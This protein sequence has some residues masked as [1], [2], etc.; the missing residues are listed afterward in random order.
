MFRIKDPQ[1]S[2]PFYEAQFGMRLVVRKDFSDFSLFFMES[3]PAGVNPADLPD[4]SSP[5]AGEYASSV[6]HTLLE[7]TWNHGTEK[8]SAFHYHSGNTAPRG[9]GHIGFL[10]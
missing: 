2:I 8:D 7:L 1:L 9:F 3:V 6:S 5:A 4:P 10:T